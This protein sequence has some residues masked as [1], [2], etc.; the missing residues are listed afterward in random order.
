MIFIGITMNRVFNKKCALTQTQASWP[1]NL[2]SLEK[3]RKFLILCYVLVTPL[4]RKAHIKNALAHF[5]I[6]NQL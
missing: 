4:S 6:L 1:K 2:F 5:L 3:L